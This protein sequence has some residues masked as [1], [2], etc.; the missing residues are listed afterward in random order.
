MSK[1][2]KAKFTITVKGPNL[3]R[4]FE[5]TMELEGGTLGAAALLY[6]MLDQIIKQDSITGETSISAK[7][8]VDE[9]VIKGEQRGGEV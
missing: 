6:T 3:H 9:L 7:L 5:G 8:I 4:K 1:P 2:Q